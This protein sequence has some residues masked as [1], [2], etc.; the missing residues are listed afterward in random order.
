MNIL[1]FVFALLAL[2][3]A[4]VAL[5]LQMIGLIE[6]ACI[7]LVSLSVLAQTAGPIIVGRSP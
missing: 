3:V 5:L 1:S 2:V 6:G 4:V 7:A